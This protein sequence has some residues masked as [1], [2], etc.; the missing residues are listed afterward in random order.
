MANPIKKALVYL[1]LAE[2]DYEMGY[3]AL[4]DNHAHPARAAGRAQ[5]RDFSEPV[6]MSFVSRTAQQ[7][8]AVEMSEIATLHPRHYSDATAIAASFREGI[9][10]IFN[11]SSM[12]DAEARRLID[13]AAGLS[14]GLYGRIE[15]VTS[16]VFLLSP[17]HVAVSGDDPNA[18]SEIDSTLFDQD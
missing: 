11:V 18:T 8:L 17:A 5:R 3:D 9:P 13:F 16:K 2:D 14:Q 1:G 7:Q 6:R 15:K 4:P 12:P 10:V